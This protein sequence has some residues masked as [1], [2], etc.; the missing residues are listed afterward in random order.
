VKTADFRF[1]YAPVLKPLMT[2]LMTGPRHSVV[3]VDAQRVL[4]RMGPGGWAF[5]ADVPRSS[6]VHAARVDGPVWGWG[7]HGWRDR[8]LVNG[9]GKGLVQLIVAPKA[10]G[11]CLFFPLRIGELTLSLEEPDAF[12]DAVSA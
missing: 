6:I 2:F 11:R 10:A 12:V 8:W 3:E 5:T 9:S 7:A 1:S 4:V